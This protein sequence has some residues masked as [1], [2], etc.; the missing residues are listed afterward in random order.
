MTELHFGARSQTRAPD[1][2][3]QVAGVSQR[4]QGPANERPQS[5][6]MLPLGQRLHSSR[7]LP[8][9]PDDSQPLRLDYRL[10]ITKH[11]QFCETI[12]IFRALTLPEGNL[13]RCVRI[14]VS[15]NISAQAVVTK[16]PAIHEPARKRQDKG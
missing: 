4:P 10:D 6:A 1:V 11:L 12:R 3:V 15:E 14:H 8:L 9:T 5:V 2:G 13:F 7:H 16:E